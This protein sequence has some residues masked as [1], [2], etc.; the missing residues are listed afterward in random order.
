MFCPFTILIPEAVW[1]QTGKTFFFSEEGYVAY[2]IM[3]LKCLTL[4]TPPPPSSVG[5]GKTVRH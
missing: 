5:L 1:G 2:H 4:C 3:Q